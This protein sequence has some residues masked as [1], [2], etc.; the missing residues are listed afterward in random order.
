[1]SCDKLSSSFAEDYAH[2]AAG[3]PVTTTSRLITLAPEYDQAT[4]LIRVGG[5]LRCSEHMEAESIH[6]VV[7]DPAH[8]VTKLLIH[9]VDKDLRHPGSERLFAEIRRRFWILH[10]REAVKRHQHSCPDCKRWRAKPL[11][12]KMADLPQAWLRLFKPPFFST[13]VDCFGLFTVKIGH[14]NEKRWGILFKCLTT[15]AVHIDILASLDTDSFLMALRRFIARRGKP[16]E[17][18]SDQGTNFKGGE[19][20]LREA[21]Q[22]LHPGLKEELSVHQI[23][24]KFNPPNAPHFGGIWEREI[25]SVKAALYATV[26]PHAIQ[27][28]V[29]RTVLI[30]VEGILN[31]KPLGYVSSD[32]ADP[33]P[34]T[35]NLLLMGRL[36]PSLPQTV[37]EES[38]LL[39][40]RRWKH[41]QILADQFWLHFIRHYLPALQTRSKWHKDTPA[42]QPDDIV[43]VMDH[44]LPRALWPVGRVT[45]VNPGVNGRIR[46][47]VVKV[48]D[49]HYLRPVAC[50]ITLPAIPDMDLEPSSP[51][52]EGKLGGPTLGAA[53]AKD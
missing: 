39:S 48:K 4:R 5:R 2:L 44:L 8:K 6:P 23:S 43:M 11:V 41:S 45:K 42:L 28:E 32:V 21:F 40:Q 49:R 29:L 24:F 1:M 19:R 17:L 52:D 13:G 25:R 50:L 35:P 30:E 33:D 47:A 51:S 27:E 16:A 3:K 37:Y 9:D 46:S 18:L 31:S 26:Q 22:A 53:V 7:L 10:G 14:R 34:V 36:D 15:R 38:E 12:P 20:E